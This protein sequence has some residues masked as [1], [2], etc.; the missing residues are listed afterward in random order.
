M[1]CFSDYIL[2]YKPWA[3][4]RLNEPIGHLVYCD[5]SGNGNHLYSQKVNDE[6]IQVA[7]NQIENS[8]TGDVGMLAIEPLLEN[9][10]LSINKIDASIPD[11]ALHFNVPKFK[12]EVYSY[13]N[14]K[15]RIQNDLS[16]KELWVDII[17]DPHPTNHYTK[18]EPILPPILAANGTQATVDRVVFNS[19]WGYAGMYTGSRDSSN[20]SIRPIVSRIY[21]TFFVFGPL[22]FVSETAIVL[23]YT[24]TVIPSVKL[25]MF[26]S[27]I[28]SDSNDAFYEIW[29]KTI[30]SANSEIDPANPF[31][32]GMHRFTFGI[33]CLTSSSIIFKISIDGQPAIQSNIQMDDGSILSFD[34]YEVYSKAA[35]FNQTKFSNLAVF[36]NTPFP[37]NVWLSAS[38]IVLSDNYSGATTGEISIISDTP[39]VDKQAGTLLTVLDTILLVGNKHRPI[40]S[41]SL[42]GDTLTLQ[43]SVTN[44]DYSPSGIPVLDSYVIF[45]KNTQGAYNGV[46]RVTGKTQSTVTLTPSTSTRLKGIIK[47]N[48]IEHQATDIR[49]VSDSILTLT[50]PPNHNFD[51]G[52]LVS[53]GY[54]S[55]TL[56]NHKWKVINTGIDV[57]TLILENAPAIAPLNGA[58]I[59]KIVPLGGGLG[60]TK[61]YRSGEVNYLCSVKNSTP[62]FMVVDDS[63]SNFAKIRLSSTDG[64]SLSDP[65]YFTRSIKN[66][67]NREPSKIPWKAA[68]DDRRLYLFISAKQ[69]T[70]SQTHILSY[71]EIQSWTDKEWGMVLIGYGSNSA[72]QNCSFNYAFVYPTWSILPTGH[73][74]CQ[75]IATAQSDARWRERDDTS[76]T[77]VMG[78][79]DSGQHIYPIDFPYNTFS[80]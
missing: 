17:I 74:L 46:W 54:F 44:D 69:N 30:V 50:V 35:I 79:A 28:D 37:S 15:E 42:S 80:S 20:V 7:T 73:L 6:F 13:R 57:F 61:T 66:T 5:I 14:T 70:L 48:N 68:G 58:A 60:W 40:I 18:I 77:N 53:V 26:V 52:D 75:S 76:T 45:N 72:E 29:S 47:F 25:K 2:A 10:T 56:L 4:C 24:G 36:Y 21:E 78:Y 64:S 12:S 71:G 51:L 16:I 39:A 19:D 41:A 62:K 8:F 11:T 23:D 55:E 3:Y 31:S 33:K 65:V 43:V 59:V 34:V 27:Y 22:V 63:Q 67:A 49:I 9:Q 1:L 38:Q 32:A